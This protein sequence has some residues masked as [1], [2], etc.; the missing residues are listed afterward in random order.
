MGYKQLY[1]TL[2]MSEF[3]PNTSEIFGNL[4]ILKGHKHTLDWLINAQIAH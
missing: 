1:P 3:S 2:T 4:L